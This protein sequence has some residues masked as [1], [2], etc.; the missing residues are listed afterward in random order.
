MYRRDFIMN[1]TLQ[2]MKEAEIFSALADRWW[3]EE[4]PFKALHAMNPVRMQ[5]MLSYVRPHFANLPKLNVLDI[6]CGGGLVCEPFARLGCNVTGI[7]QSESAID[8]A[9]QHASAQNLKILYLN[10]RLEDLSETYDVI[11]IL[12]V[13]EHVDDHEFLLR[14]AVERLSSGGLLFF[15]TLN[16]TWFSY[17][18]G[19]Y[20]AENILKWA[21]KGTH[22]WSKFLKP[23]EIILPL[24]NMGVRPLN[25]SG[26]AWSILHRQWQLSRKLH[27]N[28]IGVAKKALSPLIKSYKVLKSSVT[29]S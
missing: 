23:S 15:S 2:T 6:G 14:S 21:P 3:D 13:L 25:I 9:K 16:R 8:A 18:A 27:G 11:T 4:G 17:T 22:T 20:L 5:Y 1:P 24:Q 7:D 29:Y 19:V 26:I 12:E 10:T 28:Y